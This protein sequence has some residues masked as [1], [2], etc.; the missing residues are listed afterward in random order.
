MTYMPDAH[1]A[2]ITPREVYATAQN[3]IW[4]AGAGSGNANQPTG[5]TG[6][7]SF[8]TAI[9]GS[10][11]RLRLP[12]W[13]YTGGNAETA[14]TQS[15]TYKAALITLADSQWF[16]L[17]FGGARSLVTDPWCQAVTDPLGLHLPKG[18]LCTIRLSIVTASSA[19]SWPQGSG[20]GGPG[21]DISN[22]G[23]AYGD[24]V[25]S[26]TFTTLGNISL[27]APVI[28]C[29][30]SSWPAQSWCAIGDSVTIGQGDDGQF[31][32]SWFTRALNQGGPGM[33]IAATSDT[34]QQYALNHRSRAL[35]YAEFA[36]HAVV[37]LGSND[38]YNVGRTAVQTQTDL[39]NG[40]YIPLWRA[41]KTVVACTLKPRNTSTDSWATLANQTVAAQEPI[42]LAFNA[43]IRDGLPIDSTTLQPVAT[44]TVGA[45]RSGQAGHPVSRWIDTA[46]FVESS[47]NSG[48]W[49]VNGSANYA[50]ADGMH[51]TPAGAQILSAALITIPAS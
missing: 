32:S 6:R 23:Y 14:L 26:G 47:P 45:L 1:L 22:D 48:K 17:S 39:V 33:R 35:R 42:R 5:I 16:Q 18:T 50:T 51:P 29:V 28:T 2:A 49:I 4:G 34:A 10:M 21:V 12:G 44:G 27:W 36:T 40:V 24:L 43:W 8:K 7:F 25:D 20:Q 9:T 37:L 11:F 30:P 46:S 38:I 31:R 15:I 3:V 13:T 19:G 41:G